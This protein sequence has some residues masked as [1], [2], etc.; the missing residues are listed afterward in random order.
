[1]NVCFFEASDA[2]TKRKVFEYGI[3]NPELNTFTLRHVAIKCFTF[4]SLSFFTSVVFSAL[5][6]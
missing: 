5:L 6:F 4:S 3:I 2:N 1:M